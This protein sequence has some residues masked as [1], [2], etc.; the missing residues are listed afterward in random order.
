MF[1]AA[2]TTARKRSL[3]W[4]REIHSTPPPMPV[5]LRS[6]LIPPCHLR[7]GLPSGLFPSG[8]PTK[9]LYKFL[10]SPM[11]AT[12]PAHPILLDLICL[13]I[14]GD[15]YKLWSS[16]LCNFLHSPV[17]SSLLGPNI[18][19]STLFS[20]T[21]SLCSSLNIRDQVSH[22]YKT[23]VRIMVLYILTF[24]FLDSRREDRRLWTEW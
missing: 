23:T 21:L 2:F 18:P 3:C 10:P 13:I 4:A 5:S 9:T 20:D 24:S 11:R 6:L 8:F 7:L 1:I 12:C 19:L 16:P 17:T 14:S 22:P 15:E